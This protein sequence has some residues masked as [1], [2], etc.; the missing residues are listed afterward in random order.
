LQPID[1]DDHDKIPS[2]GSTLRKCRE[3]VMKL[4]GKLKDTE[5]QKHALMKKLAE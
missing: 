1:F 3:K 2:I 4:E 5:E